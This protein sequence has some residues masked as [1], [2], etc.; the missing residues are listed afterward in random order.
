MRKTQVFLY[1][2]SDHEHPNWICY[3]ALIMYQILQVKLTNFKD[4]GRTPNRRDILNSSLIVI[5]FLGQHGK[6]L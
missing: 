2:L 5:T 1:T 3:L 6:R 4:G